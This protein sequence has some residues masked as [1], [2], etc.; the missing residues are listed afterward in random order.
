[1][2]NLLSLLIAIL[3]V[4]G[5]IFAQDK[6]I[7]P[8]Q[9]IVGV[10]EPIALGEL[11]VIN[12][13]D[14][15]KLPE[16]FHSAAYNWKIFEIKNSELGEK[17][18]ISTKDGVFFGA[19]I[20]NQKLTAMCTVVY[21]YIVKE[22]DRVIEVATRTRLLTAQIQIG[23]PGPPPPKPDPIDPNPVFPDG[24]F[25]LAKF[26][27]DTGMSQ[28]KKEEMRERAAKALANS[29]RS[30]ASA[31]AAG[32][33][34]SDRDVLIKTKEANNSALAKCCGTTERWE[35]WSSA[36]QD[37]LYELYQSKD[38]QSVQDYSQA[39][40]EIAEGLDKVK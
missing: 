2:K 35:T 11:V 5:S 15:D 9:E 29:F 34:K 40:R 37:K 30:I 13:S 12:V 25:K 18:C 17:R 4:S 16:H 7:V 20:K 1:M 26:A 33:I 28:V 38:L 21:L 39:W 10:E 31:I 19:G 36:L 27:Y 14:I 6:F 22:D 32:T 3:L 23:K 8:N 24:R